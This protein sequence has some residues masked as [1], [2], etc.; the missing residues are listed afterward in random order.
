M[1]S[2]PNRSRRLGRSRRAAAAASLALLGYATGAAANSTFKP[3]GS[4]NHLTA[5][6]WDPPDWT[7]D[8]LSVPASQRAEETADEAAAAIQGRAF[9]ADVVVAQPSGLDPVLSLE[10][11]STYAYLQATPISGPIHM[12]W[13][14]A[15]ARPRALAP[16][17]VT[18]AS[19]EVLSAIAAASAATGVAPDYLWRT[20]YR[21]SGL[22]PWATAR[23][24]TATGLFQFIRSTWLTSLKR[25]GPALGLRH[26]ADGIEIDSQGRPYA[27]DPRD[28]GDLL[29]LRTDPLASSVIAA[30]MTADNAIRLEDLLGRRPSAGE[31]YIAHLLGVGGATTLDKAVH[32]APLYPAAAL[33]RAA[34][35]ANP[36]LFFAS[37]RSRTL[38]ELH[39]ELT[40]R[41]GV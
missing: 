3:D 13:R 10:I 6:Y 41:G 12:K 9:P 17:M 21:E 15:L 36:S 5:H 33:F 18:S 22:R 29:A 25:Y 8:V 20:A 35:R 38:V 2:P 4:S 11:K 30:A 26:A 1:P 40:T 34:A 37:G 31:V 19:S 32:V 16:I 7:L 24:S 14:I 27:A 39:N 23:S 28:E